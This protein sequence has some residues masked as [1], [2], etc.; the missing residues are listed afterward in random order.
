MYFQWETF[1][2]LVTLQKVT[3]TYLWGIWYTFGRPLKN[4]FKLVDP[5]ML[6]K[7][8]HPSNLSKSN[9]K[10][11]LWP[12]E[13]SQGQT[14]GMSWKA[15]S[16][17]LTWNIKTGL[18]VKT[19]CHTAISFPH[20]LTLFRW[21]LAYNSEVKGHSDL[22]LWLQGDIDQRYSHAKLEASSFI[23]VKIC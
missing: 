13:W 5:T 9:F 15:L 3:A 19:L 18:S 16:R 23:S 11:L 2:P 20:W 1:W 7:M 21:T 10:W 12:W 4:T 17:R 8:C 6:G 22:I 14:C